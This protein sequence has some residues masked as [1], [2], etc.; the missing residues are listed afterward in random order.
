MGS[1]IGSGAGAGQMSVVLFGRQ[2]RSDESDALSFARWLRGNREAVVGLPGAEIFQHLASGMRNTSADGRSTPPPANL[3]M[4]K[5]FRENA[6]ARRR[7]VGELA[8]PWRVFSLASRAARA[9]NFG[10]HTE[11]EPAA[12]RLYVSGERRRASL[13]MR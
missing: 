11:T 12:Q 6:T 1:V 13:P 9:P 2:S 10:P 5:L 4:E 3:P 7:S 8:L